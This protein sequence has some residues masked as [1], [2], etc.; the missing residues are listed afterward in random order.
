MHEFIHFS[1]NSD[2]LGVSFVFCISFIHLFIYLFIYFIFIHIS[3]IHS[4]SVYASQGD[5]DC[6][7]F[8]LKG[9]TEITK[10]KF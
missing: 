1:N 4:G 3:F 9:L 5:I 10:F 2:L 8:F 7:F 6:F